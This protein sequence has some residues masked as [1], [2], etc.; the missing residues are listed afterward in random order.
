MCIFKCSGGEHYS[1]F[2]TNSEEKGIQG[3]R[4][5]KPEGNQPDP[6]QPSGL[7]P[8]IRA[9]TLTG[10]RQSLVTGCPLSCRRVQATQASEDS[11]F[12]P[13][14]N[15]TYFQTLRDSFS[16]FQ[17]HRWLPCAKRSKGCT[18]LLDMSNVKFCIKAYLS[19]TRRQGFAGHK[20]KGSMLARF[21]G[22]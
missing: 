7:L 15:Q 22:I 6:K 17:I 3:E 8:L 5:A 13:I 9:Q 16:V 2:G 11:D 18:P 4:E 21:P 14:Q 19:F 1:C 10:K 20:A 12:V